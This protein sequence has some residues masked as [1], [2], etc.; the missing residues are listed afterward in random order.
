VGHG[1]SIMLGGLWIASLTLAVV[2]VAGGSWVPVAVVLLLVPAAVW[3]MLGHDGWSRWRTVALAYPLWR[4]LRRGELVLFF[5][6]KAEAVGGRVRSVEA[7]VRWRHPR[8]GLL[9]PA[10]FL[11][12]IHDGVLVRAFNRF[13]IGEAIR[14]A[15]SWARDG[16]PL[17]ISINVSPHYLCSG[18]FLPYLRGVCEETSVARELVRIEVP[19]F[20]LRDRDVASFNEAV[21]GVKELGIS[22]SIDD[23]GMGQSSLARLVDLPIDVLKID[24]RFVSAL[25]CDLK[26]D[27]VVHTAI[28]LGHALGMLVVAEGVETDEQWVQLTAWGCDLLQGFRLQRPVPPDELWGWL[29][30]TGRDIAGLGERVAAVSSYR[31]RFGREVADPAEA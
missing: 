10:E 12:V 25:A 8:R 3:L 11:P 17:R 1:E 2:A 20:P 4:A 16:R 7:L 23:F 21:R 5:Q 24:R 6:P 9:L 26:A 28:D 19:E 29:D 18:D 31:R 22:V 13:V 14:Q 15:A 30:A 27:R